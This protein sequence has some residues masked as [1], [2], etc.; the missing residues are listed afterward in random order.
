MPSIA[1]Q[2]AVLSLSRDVGGVV[3]LVYV[4]AQLSFIPYALSE[5]NLELAI[6]VYLL[7]FVNGVDPNEC[8]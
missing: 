4:F 8:G 6:Q 5:K 1:P 3:A 7:I 2:L